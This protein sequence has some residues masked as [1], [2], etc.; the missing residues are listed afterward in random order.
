MLIYGFNLNPTE[1]NRLIQNTVLGIFKT[2]LYL[3][4][5]HIFFVAIVGD[6]ERFHYFIL[7]KNFPQNGSFFKKLK[8][9]SLVESTMFEN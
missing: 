1:K 7:E 8:F 3:R 6:Y 2:V 5:W 9:G 4:D